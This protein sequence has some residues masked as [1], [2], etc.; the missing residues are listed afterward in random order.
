M[1]MSSRYFMPRDAAA[2]AEEEEERENI[3]ARGAR[4]F[5]WMLNKWGGHV[6]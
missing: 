3:C 6:T 5:C 2:A 4:A 1:S